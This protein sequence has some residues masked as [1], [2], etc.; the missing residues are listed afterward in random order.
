MDRLKGEL[1]AERRKHE[2]TKEEALGWEEQSSE[3]SRRL[4]AVE[5]AEHTAREDAKLWRTRCL[6]LESACA[7]IATQDRESRSSLLR[8][9]DRAKLAQ[10]AAIDHSVA[11]AKSENAELHALSQARGEEREAQSLR[12]DLAAVGRLAATARSELSE[13][14]SEAAALRSQQSSLESHCA[15]LRTEACAQRQALDEARC[16]LAALHVRN[17][18]LDAELLVWTSRKS[19]PD[20]PAV[21]ALREHSSWPPAA[22]D[23]AAAVVLPLTDGSGAGS[24]ASPAEK[25]HGYGQYGEGG[26]RLGWSSA[27]ADL[28]LPRLPAH[29]QRNLAALP[30]RREYP[31]NA[32]ARQLRGRILEGGHGPLFSNDLPESYQDGILWISSDPQW[33]IEQ[34]TRK[35]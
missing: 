5:A 20:G 27:A 21:D 15:D 8:A 16:C 26:A 31:R 12:S 33:L 23:I 18:H 13:S 14:R 9:Q 11:L 10:S 34:E 35:L 4:G 32:R 28:E 24:P 3:F 30:S 19:Q 1:N 22:A 25:I 17:S 7:T 6:E 2:A 29:L